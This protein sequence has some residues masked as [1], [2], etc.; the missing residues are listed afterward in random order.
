[1]AQNF[2][3]SSSQLSEISYLFALGRPQNIVTFACGR[4]GQM[5]FVCFLPNFDSLPFPM[6]MLMVMVRDSAHSGSFSEASLMN[7]TTNKFL[8]EVFD[9]S[10]DVSVWVGTFVVFGNKHRARFMTS[11]SRWSVLTFLNST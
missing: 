7:V 9:D 8:R 1:L 4:V 10:C 11:E 3:R 5:F 6:L 2:S